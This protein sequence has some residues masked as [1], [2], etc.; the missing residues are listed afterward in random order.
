MVILDVGYGGLAVLIDGD[1]V[2]VGVIFKFAI[3]RIPIF[4]ACTNGICYALQTAVA[5]VGVNEVVNQR[6]VILAAFEGKNVAVGIVGEAVHIEVVSVLP[7][8]G[9]VGIIGCF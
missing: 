7:A 1:H 3:F 5:G 6:L 2:T 4:G 8:C 9:M